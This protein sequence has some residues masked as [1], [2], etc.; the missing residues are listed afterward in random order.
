MREEYLKWFEPLLEKRPGVLDVALS[1]GA[2]GN[3]QCIGEA[4]DTIIKDL[5]D[6]EVPIVLVIHFTRCPWCR[7]LISDEG[8]PLRKVLE[9]YELPGIVALFE[10][11]SAWPSILGKDR[12]VGGEVL[13]TVPRVLG[14]HKGREM[15]Q[16]TGERTPENLIEFIAE[17]FGSP[18]VA[19]GSGVIA[20]TRGGEV[21]RPSTAA[22]S[23]EV[24]RPS[25]AATSGDGDKDKTK[26]KHVGMDDLYECFSNVLLGRTDL[27]P[28]PP[29]TD[30]R[31]LEHL[32]PLH[33]RHQAIMKRTD[34]ISFQHGNTF[35]QSPL[36]YMRTEE[37]IDMAMRPPPTHASDATITPSGDG[38]TTYNPKTVF[39]YDSRRGTI[40]DLEEEVMAYINEKAESERG[41]RRKRNKDLYVIDLATFMQKADD[42]GVHIPH[43]IVTPVLVMENQSLVGAE[44]LMLRECDSLT[45]FYPYDDGLWRTISKS[46][47]ARDM[48]FMDENEFITDGLP[49]IVTRHGIPF[50]NNDGD[51]DGDGDSE[52]D[53]ND[54]ET[55]DGDE[56]GW[57][58]KSTIQ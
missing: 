2:Y 48:Y 18:V 22:T 24:P 52:G 9:G 17:F 21:P 40:G 45:D 58:D 53:D 42:L 32:P 14:V 3:D 37:V 38:K 51:D 1:T 20:A 50:H 15:I 44:I 26:K 25:T 43:D 16:F 57:E 29:A 46:F 13:D 49:G 54:D 5:Y 35:T 23:G 47:R 19:K 8:A 11:S 41:N 31:I 28:V 39:I 10:A 4:N 30:G 33:E 55:E 12:I 6:S 56:T 34:T 36:Q 27:I 7:M